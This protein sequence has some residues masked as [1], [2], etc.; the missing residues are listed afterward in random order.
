MS[1][2]RLQRRRIA[3]VLFR[4]F[5]AGMTMASVGVLALLLYHVGRT[6]LKWVDG[7][8]L[9]SF[10]SR[11]PKKAG[12]KSA[13][14]GT[15]WLISMIAAI[16]VPVGVAAAVYLEEYA[17]KGR[18]SRLIEINI[19]NLAGVP[20]IVYGML[21]LVIFVR[22]FALD[23]SLV[24]GA[25]TMSLLILPVIIIA[26]REAIRAVPPSIRQASFAL[27]ATQWQ[28]IRS[29]VLLSAM[30]G[31]MTGIIISLSRALGETAPL[32]MI[33][34]L[35]YVAFVPENPMDQFTTLPIQIFNWTSRP[36][37]DFHEIAAGGIVVLLVVL[38]CMNALAVFI[39]HATERA[40][41]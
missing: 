40:Q 41:K 29:H 27:G 13:L 25:L 33:G 38:L 18:I 32:V 3:A 20:S 26:S 9:T 31:I 37:S 23:R 7:Q 24:A 4:Y 11:F 15:I 1:N 16:A 28:T 10:P 8:F 35:T 6:G 5:C 30:P 39:R 34:A 14:W 22:F 17:K 19:A 12:I 36:Q 2:A 21:G